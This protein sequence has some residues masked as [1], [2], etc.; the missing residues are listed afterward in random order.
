MQF[1]ASVIESLDAESCA[2]YSEQNNP[3]R[4]RWNQIQELQAAY[5]EQSVPRFTGVYPNEEITSKILSI[6]D[7]HFPLSRADLLEQILNEHADADIV[8]CN[9][10]ILEGYM[11]STFDKDR[12]IAALD[13]Y[14]C[15]FAFVEELSRRFPQV[16][17]VEGNHDVR[18]ARQLKSAGFKKDT[19]QVL[20]PNLIARIANG[21]LL[22][23]SGM[24]VE[25]LDFS[26]VH[27][28]Q[29]E[30]WYVKIGKTLFCHP[31]SRG[32]SKPGW[33][34]QKLQTYFNQ[35]YIAGEYDSIVCGHTHKIYKGIINSTLLI[36][37]GCLAGLM[38]YAHSPRMQ[39]STANGMNG[40]AII[41]QDK[42]GNTNFN[43]SGPVFLGEVMPPKKSVIL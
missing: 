15:A 24:V 20:R 27:Y 10:D 21:E 39:Y 2:N 19:T 26:N 33:T 4:E 8:V 42:D 5:V 7:I 40:Y 43:E 17:L 13:E 41:Y 31:H 34:A 36:E 14:R 35:R 32:S 30:G 3:Y 6:S 9:G 11:F 18:P 22:D 28:E 25:K 38:M 23:S 1:G 29:R 12:S 16:V 37:Q